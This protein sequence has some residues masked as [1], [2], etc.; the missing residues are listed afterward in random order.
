MF[1]WPFPKSR[2]KAPKKSGCKKGAS[3]VDQPDISLHK[4]TSR[5]PLAWLSIP[6]WI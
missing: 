6:I 4:S 2:Q 1:F 3:Y 5:P